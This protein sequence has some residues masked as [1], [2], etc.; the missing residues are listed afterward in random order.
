[1]AITAGAVE[2]PII[3][4]FERTLLRR[5]GRNRIQR[6]RMPCIRVTGLAE[7]G[8]FVLQQLIVA[9]SMRRVAI[10]AIFGNRRVLPEERTTFLGMTLE[11]LIVHARRIDQLVTDCAMRVVTIGALHLSL[12]DRMMRD[13][14]HLRTH[15]LVAGAAQFRLGLFCKIFIVA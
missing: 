10:H 8:H 9:R 15:I 6:P 7:E 3:K 4:R 11:A 1:M 13:P 12:S 2:D 5:A 14:L